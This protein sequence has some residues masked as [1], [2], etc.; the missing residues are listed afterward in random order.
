MTSKKLTAGTKFPEITV[1]LV[2]G[3]A[4]KLGGG[5]DSGRWQLVVVY[6]GLHCPLCVT[7]LASLDGLAAE[8]ADMGTDIVAVSGDGL[9]KATKQVAKGDLKI[10]VAYG[11][12]IEQMQEMG[13]YISHPR[14]PE[15]TDQPFPEPGL[16]VVRPDGT[17][18]I[19][20]VSNAPFARPDLKMILK[21]IEF[22]RDKGYP[23]R[24][25]F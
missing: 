25:T 6:R 7:Y 9:E 21:G 13:L 2:V 17:L 12:S 15:E 11:L 5:N 8:Y 19:I 4:Q 20:D 14:S 22:G 18:Q 10:P 3:G 24:G 23:V 1:P 16:F